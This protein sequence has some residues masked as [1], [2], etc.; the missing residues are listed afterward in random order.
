MLK[1]PP[2]RNSAQTMGANDVGENTQILRWQTNIAKYTLRWQTNIAK[3]RRN[4]HFTHRKLL[5]DGARV[6]HHAPS[7][8]LW[9]GIIASRGLPITHLPIKI[10]VLT[11]RY[12][13]MISVTVTAKRLQRLQ[14]ALQQTVAC[15][16]AGP[17]VVCSNPAQNWHGFRGQQA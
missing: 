2:R 15:F 7:R 1:Y 9:R 17:M 8:H 10:C 12:L 3:F 13:E 5:A 14:D 11:S 4:C 6:L 16:P